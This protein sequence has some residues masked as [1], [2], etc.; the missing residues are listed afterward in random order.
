[1]LPRGGPKK[2]NAPHKQKPSYAPD[3]DVYQIIGF[4]W[5]WFAFSTPFWDLQTQSN[6]GG[7]VNSPNNPHYN[8]HCI[9]EI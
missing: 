5:V 1:M 7:G 3:H 4:N 8:R 9:S 6:K 2:L